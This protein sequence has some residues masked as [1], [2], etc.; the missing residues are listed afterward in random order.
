LPKEHGSVTLHDPVRKGRP[1]VNTG[2]ATYADR[3]MRT[4]T[5]PCNQ[6]LTSL[7]VAHKKVDAAVLN[8]YG[9]SHKLSAEAILERLLALNLDRAGARE[10]G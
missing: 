2:G 4:T 9:W 5:N 3:E 6:R 7:D 8:G 10:V 1:I